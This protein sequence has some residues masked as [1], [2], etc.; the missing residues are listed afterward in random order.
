MSDLLLFH[1]PPS[2]ASKMVRLVLEEKE[3]E[4]E[5]RPINSLAGE[6]FE[7]WYVED[8]NEFCEEPS[9]VH[10]NKAINNPRYICRYLDTHFNTPPLMY[11]DGSEKREDAEK[12][13]EMSAEFPPEVLYHI[14][15]GGWRVDMAR[16]SLEWQIERLEDLAQ[17]NPPLAQRYLRKATK[18]REILV[19]IAQPDA[20]QEGMGE[21]ETLLDRLEIQL[22]RGGNKYVVGDEYT[23]ADAAWTALL[24]DLDTYGMAWLWVDG[25][26]RAVARYYRR[27]RERPSFESALEDHPVTIDFIIPYYLRVLRR[28]LLPA[29]IP[30]S[31]SMWARV[32]GAAIGAILLLRLLRGGGAPVP[33]PSAPIMITFPNLRV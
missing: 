27:M 6:E 22:Q 25:T 30:Q 33:G 23:L 2:V 21:I 10:E 28:R 26:R 18:V 24:S 11:P 15:P 17:E 20:V 12:W 19:R 9:L 4:W 7:P 16:D 13:F 29:I 14:H 5:S 31:A 8:L 3:L 32:G 1:F